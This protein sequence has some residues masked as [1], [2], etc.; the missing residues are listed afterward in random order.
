MEELKSSHTFRPTSGISKTI[1]SAIKGAV[2]K[3]G[4]KKNEMDQIGIFQWLVL[5]E[6]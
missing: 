1:A 5:E 4:E 3:R 2:T 6:I